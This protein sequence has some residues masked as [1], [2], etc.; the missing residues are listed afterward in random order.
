MCICE[1]FGYIVTFVQHNR[2]EHNVFRLDNN[3]KCI[4]AATGDA[5]NHY[6]TLCRWLD[7]L[8]ITNHSSIHSLI[9]SF[10]LKYRLVSDIDIEA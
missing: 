5:M 8:S 6:K 3:Y 10:T 9:H 1:S 2:S 4:V 7:L